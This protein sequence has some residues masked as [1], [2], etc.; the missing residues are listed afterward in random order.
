MLMFI[1]W[2]IHSWCVRYN[3]GQLFMY[4]ELNNKITWTLSTTACQDNCV[5]VVSTSVKSGDDRETFSCESKYLVWARRGNSTQDRCLLVCRSPLV[6]AGKIGFG[7][8]QVQRMNQNFLPQHISNMGDCTVRA[9]LPP[10][11]ERRNRSRSRRDREGWECQWNVRNSR[12][13]GCIWKNPCQTWIS[14]EKKKE[15]EQKDKKVLA[16]ASHV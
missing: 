7:K 11:S 3:L 12:S 5:R 2:S 14:E 8:W 9:C 15:V 16:A 6:G 4:M 10:E 1:Y 13:L